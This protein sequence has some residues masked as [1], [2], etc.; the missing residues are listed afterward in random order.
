[1]NLIHE[2]LSCPEFESNMRT[3]DGGFVT[4]YYKIARSGMYEINLFGEYEMSLFLKVIDNTPAKTTAAKTKVAKT[5]VAVVKLQKN[6]KIKIGKYVIKLSK[7]QYKSLVNAYK[8][9]KSKSITIKTKYKYKVKKRY[10][11]TFKKYKTLKLVKTFRSVYYETFDE[12]WLDGWKKVSEYC[13]TK[14]NPKSKEGL[15]L[16][17]YRYSVSKWVKKYKKPVYKTKKYPVKA[18][19]VLKSN[20]QATIKVYS[21]GKT[22]KSAYLTIV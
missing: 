13:F 20:K 3:D 17:S 7:K 21:N 16:S 8:K 6:R 19:I 14:K 4:F 10:I 1:V 15:G 5:K 2:D 11:K 22:F 9:G 18:K 12:M